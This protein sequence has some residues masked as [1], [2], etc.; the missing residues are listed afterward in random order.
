MSLKVGDDTLKALNGTLRRALFVAGYTQRGADKYTMFASHDGRTHPSGVKWVKLYHHRTWTWT[1]EFQGDDCWFVPRPTWTKVTEQPAERAAVFLGSRFKDDVWTVVD[2]YTGEMWTNLTAQA[3]READSLSAPRFRII[4]R[5]RTNSDERLPTIT[6]IHKAVQ[7]EPVFAQIADLT[8][9]R[10]LSDAEALEVD[11]PRLVIGDTE[12]AHR[13]DTIQQGVHRKPDRPVRLVAVLPADD[14]DARTALVYRF[15]PAT[16]IKK[17]SGPFPI[18]WVSGVWDTKWGLKESAPLCWVKKPMTYDP[19]TGELS[20]PDRLTHEAALAFQE[21]QT[22]VTVTVLPR[23]PLSHGAMTS[24]RAAVQPFNHVLVVGEAYFL[25]EKGQE[26]KKRCWGVV[27]RLALK[28]L[29]AAGGL[30]YTLKPLPGTTSGTYYLG[31]D[32]SNH[33]RENRSVLAMVLVNWSGDVIGKRVVPLEENNERIPT[34]LLT[35]V[36]PAW[37]KELS[38]I[39]EHGPL[40]QVDALHPTRLIVHRDGQFMAGEAEELKEAFAHLQQLDLVA[41]SKSSSLRVQ[42]PSAE[43]RVLPLSEGRAAIFSAAALEGL[44]KP[45]EIRV[46]GD[47]DLLQAAVQVLWLSKMRTDELYLPGRLPLTTFLADKIAGLT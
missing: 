11:S 39:R 3:I 25:D 15:G 26:E 27:T 5:S 46:I 38:E 16:A 40:P 2:P 28:V 19:G 34:H 18:I 23:Q 1:F 45:L 43:P 6:E 30:P 36:L 8:Q 9:P 33:H 13:K 22:L 32:L 10:Q 21:G 20:H 17:L 42:L 31:L 4:Y 7:G 35:E 44:T 37:M 14:S 24:L 29:R 12:I 47:T 41:V